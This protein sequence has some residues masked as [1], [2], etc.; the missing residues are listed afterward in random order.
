MT[1]NRELDAQPIGLPRCSTKFLYSTSVYISQSAV[2]GSQRG[3]GPLVPLPEGS[4]SAHV[5]GQGDGTEEASGLEV[6]TT[7]GRKA[8]G[9]EM[10]WGDVAVGPHGQH[11]DSAGP[12]QGGGAL[13]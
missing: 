3:H 12:G 9:A 5:R 11:T 13:G 2:G 7:S 4:L 1:R 8:E 6:E 10:P